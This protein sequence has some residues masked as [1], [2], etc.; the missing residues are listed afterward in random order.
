[1]TSRYCIACMLPVFDS[2]VPILTI[3][4]IHLGMHVCLRV[5]K[6]VCV[7]VW[8]GTGRA[9]ELVSILSILI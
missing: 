1:M 8:E 2:L 3:Q 5:Q 9:E 4:W 7:A 6:S